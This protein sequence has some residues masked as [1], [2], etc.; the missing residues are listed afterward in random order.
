MDFQ[1]VPEAAR[2]EIIRPTRWQLSIYAAAIAI[3]IESQLQLI[4]LGFALLN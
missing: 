2:V 3:S 4:S 1:F